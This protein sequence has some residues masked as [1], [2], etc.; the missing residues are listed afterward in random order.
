MSSKIVSWYKSVETRSVSARSYTGVFYFEHMCRGF[1][2]SVFSLEIR[3]ERLQFIPG[4][5]HVIGK[6]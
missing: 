5:V 1:T 2:L 4:I 3:L 6:M